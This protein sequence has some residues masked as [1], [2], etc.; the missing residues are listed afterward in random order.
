M[1]TQRWFL[2]PVLFIVACNRGPDGPGQADLDTETA[3]E[4]DTSSPE[5]S[6]SSTETQTESEPP[7][8]SDTATASDSE[9]DS[10]S[11]TES[12]T[13][14]DGDG[15][16][17]VILAPA[18]PADFLSTSIVIDNR[19]T[20]LCRVTPD[21]V[22]LRPIN[23]D[24]VAI[25]LRTGDITRS[26]WGH[27]TD[28]DSVYAV[29]IHTEDL[30]NGPV[31]IECTA[32]DS[33]AMSGSDTSSTWL[34]LGPDIHILSP[35]PDSRHGAGVDLLFQVSPWPVD[36]DD[37]FA[38][39]DFSSLEARLGNTDITDLLEEVETGSGR[40]RATI[41]F[42]DP[43]FDQP[44]DGANAIAITVANSRP[45]AAATRQQLAVF[46]A[47]S[48][49]PVISV[50]SPAEGEL[51][52]G[53]FPIAVH[54]SDQ[55]G[56]DS[57]SVVAHIAG[58]I[59]LPLLSS[60]GSLFFADFDS[61]LLS[62]DMVFP[63]IV[64][65]AED[66]T[67]NESIFGFVVSLDNQ[68]PLLS[69]DP[70]YLREARFNSY[71][72]HL[73]CSRRF[74]PLG[75]VDP[76]GLDPHFG[77]AADDGECVPQ[78]VEL[79]ARVED[80]GN[81]A[82]AVSGVDIPMA[83]VLETSVQ[84][85]VL[86]DED[87]ALLVDTNDDGYCDDVNPLLAPGTVSMTDDSVV[88]INLVGLTGRGEA[89]FRP[90]PE[91]STPVQPPFDMSAGSVEADCHAGIEEFA[92][93]PLCATS[94]GTRIIEGPSGAAAIFTIAPVTASGCFGNPFD[95]VASNVSDGWACLAVRGTDALG[96]V[97]IS[98]PLRLCFDHDGDGAEC[99]LWGTIVD[100]DL[101]DCTGT[102][103]DDNTVDAD[104][105]CVLREQDIASPPLSPR[106]WYFEDYPDRQLRHRN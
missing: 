78:L 28:V 38:E 31:E 43:R 41:D 15:P 61:R 26:T 6:A 30:P 20:V 22:T 55:S 51:V 1:R 93:G 34:D 102:W 48:S 95:S 69:L 64:I 90:L 89:D 52:G 25:T 79:R 85:F 5:D 87:G 58:S 73:E 80:R 33:A 23:R 39:P 4:T 84:L 97:G 14:A 98:A 71:F 45:P 7:P 88:V 65:R 56:V 60:G 2:V 35:E 66:T 94:P 17:V 82:T 24:S 76:A 50:A 46:I 103:F 91:P 106:S 8:D 27:P 81:S 99:D 77:D 54:V 44:L 83:G 59:A 40:F 3:S 92:P 74:D 62:P 9:T 57:W 13:A 21:P 70:P 105:D 18:L 47:D 63:S 100:L 75:G 12:E 16:T 36:E 10:D 29:D 53:I 37:P 72:N 96:N 101:P 68:P 86:D 19:I 67:G 11:A 49:G 42:S 32:T 104:E